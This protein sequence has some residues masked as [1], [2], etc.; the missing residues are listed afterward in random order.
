MD[1]STDNSPSSKFSGCNSQFT[2]PR[3][4]PEIS[5][6]LIEPDQIVP[7]VE[8]IFI[9]PGIL[10]NE[11]TMFAGKLIIKKNKYKPETK[12]IYFLLT[13]MEGKEK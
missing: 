7:D 11:T 6:L 1:T 8:E 4:M 10:R 12:E 3:L 2:E 13:E 9:L 5:S